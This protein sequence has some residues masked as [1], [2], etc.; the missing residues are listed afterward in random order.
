MNETSITGPGLPELFPHMPVPAFGNAWNVRELRLDAPVDG[1]VTA[2]YE[3]AIKPAFEVVPIPP[4][5]P[6]V[7][8]AVT[9]RHP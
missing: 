9:G 4:R 1:M 8:E 3:V 6:N 7:Y 2:T 5:K